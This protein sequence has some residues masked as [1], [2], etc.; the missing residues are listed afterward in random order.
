MKPPSKGYRLAIVGGSSLLGKELHAVLEERKFPVCRLVT[1]GGDEEEPDLPIVDL[2][3]HSQVAVADENVGDAELDFA[4]LAASLRSG[5]PRPPFL[6]QPGRGHCAVIDLGEGLSEAPDGVL[7]IPFLDHDAFSTRE[8]REARLFVSPHPAAIVISI[9]LLRLA[10]RFPVKSAVAHVFG[11]ASE[12]GP[13]GIE[14]LQKQTVNL[15]SFQKIPR[16]VFGAQLAFNLLPRLGRGRG[17]N[18]LALENRIR[19]Q[20]RKYL[21]DRAPLPAIRLF[22][23]PVFYSMAF[24]IYVKMAGPA[25]PEALGKALAGPPIRLRQF[26][27]HAPSPVEAAG[28]GD[29]LVDAIVPEPD[30]PAGVWVWAVADNIR[31]AALNAVE[32]AESLSQQTRFESHTAKR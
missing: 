7:S 9:L 6:C 26:S 11:P 15:L 25:A 20:L 22:Q 18:L 12:I 17:G 3:E 31:L 10:A 29:I 30:Q 23:V 32:I 21:G 24:S 19:R 28:S 1:F 16:T 14:E 27:E 8:F 5:A 4:F 13:R 2:R